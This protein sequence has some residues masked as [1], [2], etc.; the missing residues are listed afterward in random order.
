VAYDGPPALT[1]GRL[2][3]A[4]TFEPAIVA[5][6]LVA[7]GLY[8]YGVRVLRRRGVAWSRGRSIAFL[9]GGLGTL[10][11]ALLGWMA[12]YDDTLFWAHMPST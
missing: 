1:W 4:W 9:L 10:A 7:A 11:Y 5:A 3:T 8:L 12:V 6:L 2:V